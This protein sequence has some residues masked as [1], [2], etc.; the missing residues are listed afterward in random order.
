VP[1][2]R[3]VLPT[4]S[5]LPHGEGVAGPARESAAVPTDVPGVPGQSQQLV[6]R[7]RVPESAG[8]VPGATDQEVAPSRESHCDP[9]ILVTAE[10]R[11]RRTL[12]S[13]RE[14]H[15]RVLAAGC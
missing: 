3:E 4:R 13:V 12:R 9:A 8:P 1:R 7:P 6:S 14:G 10:T 5:D 2:Q 15:V 11:A